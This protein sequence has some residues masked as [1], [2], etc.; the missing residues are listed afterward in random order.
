MSSLKRNN[1]VVTGRPGAQPVVLSHGY[2]DDQDGWRLVA[3]AFEE[4]YQVV[5]FDHV[6]AGHSDL[7]AYDK[8]RYSTLGGYADDLL[9][10]LHEM[11]LKNVIFVGHSVSA[12]IGLL[13][14]VKEADRFAA[15]VMV[16]PSARFIDDDGYTGGFSE[17][18]IDELLASLDA[19][20]LGWSN[21]IAPVMMGNADRPQL[22][23]ELVR[24]FCHTDPAIASHFAH[25]TFQSDHR[26]S[27]PLV[28]VPTLILQC[29]EDPIAPESAGRYLHQ[30]I[31][32]SRF[33]QLNATGHC[34]NLSAPDEVVSA[35]T[36]FLRDL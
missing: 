28:S 3:P 1:V 25:V 13:A 18:Q 4:Q 27:L 6:G 19:N 9:E 21:M 24:K 34:P 22:G 17:P 8:E 16:A 14:S 10:I 35:V 7:G 23:Q 30:H 36:A 31:R 5:R 32:N 2:G 20:Y 15:L 12:T 33:V 11:D 26:S 29:A